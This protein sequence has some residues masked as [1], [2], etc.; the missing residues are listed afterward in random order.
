MRILMVSQ[1]F[2]PEPTLKGMLFAK[3]LTRRGHSVEVLTG[4]P[5]YPVGRFYPGYRCR[6]WS[7]SVED[8]VRV[9]RT[10][11][12]PSHDRSSVRR[13]ATYLS[14]AASAALLGPTLVSKPDVIYAYQPPAT[15]AIPAFWLRKVF[16]APV[17][18]DVQDL[19]PDTLSSTGMM[20]NARLLA[21]L[22]MVCRR[23]Y[24]SADRLAVLSPGIQKRLVEQGVRP[25]NIEVIYNWG[26]VGSRAASA[27]TPVFPVDTNR[28]NI[29]FAG[30]MGLAQSLE[31]VLD[32]AALC[33]TR[34]PEVYFH[35]VGD[36]VD[37]SRL[38][39]LAKKK[40]LKN[41]TFVSSL[42]ASQMDAVYQRADALLVNLRA[43][44][45]FNASIP[46]KTQAYLAAGRPIL[47]AARGD[48]ADL[49]QEAQA[50]ISCEPQDAQSLV[51]AIC[52]L[53][54][55]HPA[56]RLAMGA[57]GK[58]Y[59]AERLSLNVGVDRF[60]KLFQQAV[61]T[62]PVERRGTHVD[63]M[64][65]ILDVACAAA[66][67][68]LLA[69]LLACIAAAIRISLG[70]P[71]LFRQQRPGR[72]G[73]VFKVV[74]F[75]TM[76]QAVSVDGLPLPDS[77]RLTSLGKWLRESSL[78]ELPELWNVL[79]GDMSLVG[80]RPLLMQY[81]S[82]Y[83]P[84][85]QR[86]HEVRPGITGWAQVNGRNALT[87]EERFDLDV[88]YVNN[89]SLLLDLKILWLTLRTVVRREGISAEGH[90]T[91][92]EFRGSHMAGQSL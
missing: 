89:R 81:L 30:N 58:T 62:R 92:P 57:R 19:W 87:W 49:I 34:C 9:V 78:D 68:L 5:N 53:T 3:E 85:Q 4:F 11:L 71:I 25:E 69:P 65:R 55:L 51:D 13:A 84:E 88:W 74:K 27:K 24:R 83:T 32:A 12:Y 70:S 91:M 54:S 28:F 42:P 7:A 31:T 22:A 75:R 6:L 29:V 82:L 26:L 90:A 16:G 40:A 63:Q 41:V 86:R 48:A 2:D 35:F 47:M 67:L 21:G 77:E 60:E 33:E 76:S 50:G 79:K 10:A 56:E 59:Y 73:R 14:F 1:W 45:L 43:D 39:L 46:S 80:P 52:K 44:E 20:Q 61:A 36:G 72:D 17:V 38:E 37:R 66:G 18:Y 64:K 8:G 15:I 23:I